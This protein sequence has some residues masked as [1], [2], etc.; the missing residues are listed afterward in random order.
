LATLFEFG[1]LF[2]VPIGVFI[3]DFPEVFLKGC[4]EKNRYD[5]LKSCCT[6]CFLKPASDLGERERR[7]DPSPIDEDPIQ[8][9]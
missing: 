2:L 5:E 3:F 7:A 8:M 6:L 4:L 9:E 1:T